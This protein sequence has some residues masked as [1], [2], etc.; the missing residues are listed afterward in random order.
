MKTRY[1]ITTICMAALISCS[2]EDRYDWDDSS[3]EGIW[4]KELTSAKYCGRKTGTAECSE[5]ALYLMNELEEMGYTATSQDFV[6]MDSLK[7]KNIIVEIPGINDSVIIIGA[8]Y[9]G[10]VDSRKHQ[11]AND[12]ASGVVALL[13]I[14]EPLSSQ[15]NS[16][17][18]LCFWDGEEA[19]GGS[20]FNGSRYFI[21]TFDRVKL[22]KWYC[23]IDCCGRTGDD[24][25]FYYSKDM[26]KR[27]KSLLTPEFMA[28]YQISIITKVQECHS[29]DYES[30]SQENIPFCGW[31]DYGVMRYIHGLDDTY[32]YISTE[33]IRNVASI[34]LTLISNI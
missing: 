10:A 13:S 32:R 14:A 3:K 19:T 22:I 29:S 21:S 30:F 34:T 18:L 2:L 15:C 25:Y 12:N 5:S 20:V 9:D 26:E 28:N 16:T 23:N 33:K 31:N 8:H 27:C 11:A 4:L 24:I 7:M 6:F 17:V 1:F